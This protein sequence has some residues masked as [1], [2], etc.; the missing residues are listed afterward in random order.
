MPSQTDA[1]V[2]FLD[3]SLPPLGRLGRRRIRGNNIDALPRPLM[4]LL[5]GLGVTL[6]SE[7]ASNTAVAALLMPVAAAAA[8]ALGR[9]PLGLMLPTALAASCGFMLPVATAP[10]AIAFGTGRVDARVM[11]RHGAA[12]D[13][14]GVVVIAA[15]VLLLL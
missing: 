6:L 14:V 12:L 13:V 2:G 11:A 3:A 10:N 7:V 15:A 4:L 5:L 9:D 8:G 1:C